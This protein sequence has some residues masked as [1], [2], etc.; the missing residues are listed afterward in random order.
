[1]QGTSYFK[2][3]YLYKGGSEKLAYFQMTKYLPA[4]CT[5]HQKNGRKYSTYY[6]SMAVGVVVGSY[7]AGQEKEKSSLLGERKESA[8]PS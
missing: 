8:Q 5:G 3:Q 2:K 4:Y 7:A 6:F 1:M